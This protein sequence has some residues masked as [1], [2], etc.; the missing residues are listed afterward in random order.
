MTVKKILLLRVFFLE[1]TLRQRSRVQDSNTLCSMQNYA[2]KRTCFT[3]RKNPG[4]V[5][6]QYKLVAVLG[7]VRLAGHGY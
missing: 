4:E 7:V 2:H 6:R 1:E 3:S 5:V